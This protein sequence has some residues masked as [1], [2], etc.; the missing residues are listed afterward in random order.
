MLKA[1]MDTLD[2]MQEQMR[3]VIIEIEMLRKNP[4]Q[5]LEIKLKKKKL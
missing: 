3:N 5:M 1:L 4:K 2:A